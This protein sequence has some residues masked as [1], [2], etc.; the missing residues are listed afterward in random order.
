[1]DRHDDGGEILLRWM[2]VGTVRTLQSKYTINLGV[3][4]GIPCVRRKGLEVNPAIQV[5]SN[6]SLEG[7]NNSMGVMCRCSRF[8]GVGMAG[9]TV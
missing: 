9:M 3:A 6:D 8:R 5:H 2:N 4:F 7:Q 1:M